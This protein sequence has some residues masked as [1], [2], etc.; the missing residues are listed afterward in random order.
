MK[1][2]VATDGSSESMDALERC[3]EIAEPLGAYVEVVHVVQPELHD[4]G[5]V[6]SV[7]SA[8]DAR[9]KLVFE[10]VSDAEDRGLDLLEE[11]EAVLADSD[12]GYDTGLLYGDPAPA[13]ADYAEEEGF[14]GVFV[15]HKGRSERMEYH[16]GSVAADLVQRATVPVTVVR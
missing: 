5:G 11:A 15:G 8:V 16:L 4:L 3:L 10:S 12:V 6:E 2:L 1:Y 7:E 9:E 14:D 13:I